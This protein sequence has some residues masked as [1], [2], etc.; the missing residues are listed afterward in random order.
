MREDLKAIEIY[1]ERGK[2]GKELERVYRMLRNRDL[3]LT[4]YSNLYANQGALTPGTDPNDTIDGMSVDKIDEII[5]QLEAGTYQWKPTKRVY[6]PKKN[7]KLRPLGLP[8]WKDKLLQEAIRILLTAYYEPQFFRHSHGFRPQRGCH[9]ALKEI[10]LEWRGAAWFIEGDIK[11]CF[12]H[13]NHEILLE[14]MGRKI[15]DNRFIKLLKEMLEA[16]YLE[17]WRYNPTFSGTPQGGVISPLL[18]NIYLNELDKFVEEKLMPKYH[19]PE[20]KQVNPEWNRLTWAI[21]VARKK[22]ERTTVEKLVKARDSVPHGDQNGNWRALRY[23]RY[24]DDFLLGF[25]GPKQE[26]E[27]IKAELRDFLKAELKLEMSEDKTLVTHASTEPARFLSYEIGIDTDENRKAMLARGE[28]RTLTKRPM[29]RIPRDVIVKWSEKAK[30]DGITIHRTELLNL[31]DYDIVQTYDAELRGLVN[32]YLMAVNVSRLYSVK[33]LMLESLVKTLATKHKCKTTRIYRKHI[34]TTS[35][36]LKAIKV[37]VSRKDK[38]DLVATF[39]AQPIRY[40]RM[41]TIKDRPESVIFAGR[42][43]LIDRVQ[44]EK[45][46]LCGDETNVEVHHINKLKDYREKYKGKEPPDWLKRMMEIRRKTLV[47]CHECHVKIHNGTYDGKSLKA[48]Q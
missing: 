7:G 5:Q 30:K 36:G 17:D 3:F 37:V 29:L 10:N 43:Q 15:K 26:A 6:I 8:G 9:T 4:A 12:D 2:E 28:T 16:G 1:S 41:G 33:S 44:A 34:Y 40:Q 14:I 42:T 39:G 45:C 24:A 23:V 21:G 19:K 47:V 20:L 31:S 27:D 18:S 48:K 35:D 22:G 46:E 32:Y 38:P 13:I 11:G 25:K